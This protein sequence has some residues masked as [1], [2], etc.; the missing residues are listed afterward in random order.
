MIDNGYPI[1]S[2]TGSKGSKTDLYIG[3]GDKIE[4]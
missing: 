4:F 3:N 1:I 2:G